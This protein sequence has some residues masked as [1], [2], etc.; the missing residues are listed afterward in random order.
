MCVAFVRLLGAATTCPSMHKRMRNRHVIV[1]RVSV[2]T[3]VAI[4]NSEG[5]AYLVYLDARRGGLGLL[6]VQR[7]P[8]P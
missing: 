4:T 3:V 1:V 8:N 6:V 2:T 5:V 7:L